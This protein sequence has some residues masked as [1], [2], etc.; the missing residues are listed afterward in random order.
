M[1]QNDFKEVLHIIACSE[2]SEKYYREI[3]NIKKRR[4]IVKAGI[5]S[6]A[7]VVAVLSAILSTVKLSNSAKT[8]SPIGSGD[9]VLIAESTATPTDKPSNNPTDIIDETPSLSTKEPDV[10]SVFGIANPRQS[11]NGE[12]FSKKEVEIKQLSY[13]GLNSE[14]RTLKGSSLGMD[15]IS[16][17]VFGE[18]GDCPGLYYNR[19]KDEIICLYHEFLNAAGISV[20]EGYQAEFIADAEKQDYFVVRIYE[21]NGTLTE[22]LWVFDRSTGHASSLSLPEG[23]SGYNELYVYNKS[24]CNGRLSAGVNTDDGKHFI[25]VCNTETG[26]GIKLIESESAWIS[27]EFLSERILLITNDGYSFYNVDTGKRVNVIGEYNYYADGKV[28]SIKNWGWANHSDVEVAAYDAETGALL[29]NEYVLVQTVLDNGSKVFLTK[30]TTTGEETVILADYS[31]NCYTWT[32]DGGYFYAYSAANQ[33][34]LCYSASDGEWFL[35]QVPAFNTEPVTIDGKRQAVFV[36]Y[37][38]SAADNGNEVILYFTRTIEEIQETPDYEDE[39]V[40]SPY[41]D[42]YR[43]MKFRNFADETCFGI[44]VKENIK[45]DGT[46][47]YYGSAD[48]AGFKYFLLSCLE[49]GTLVP[50]KQA[51]RENY[52]SK[53]LA[54]RCGFLMMDFF[55]EDDICYLSLGYHLPVP[56]G[57][58]TEIYEIPETL[59]DEINGCCYNH[60]RTGN[61]F[62]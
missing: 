38:I 7:A 2:E 61:L 53:E 17:E 32:R 4:K 48:M 14:V 11:N 5:I 50:D 59:F 24:L 42:K 36:S 21:I 39:R 52:Q 8:L 51:T 15:L 56:Y 23:C 44:A 9:E 20:N 19:D 33:R 41:W 60:M 40:D 31:Q 3:R 22:L 37:A 49:K 13:T 58:T 35:N 16:T 26:E 43:D 25:Y 62:E 57:W 1:A 34:L 46:T 28:F 10:A 29:D 30:N 45:V 54:L 27:A 55:H 47:I 18:H 6:S 12:W